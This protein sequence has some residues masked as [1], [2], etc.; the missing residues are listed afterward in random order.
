MK[1]KESR[2]EN[3]LVVLLLN[4]MKN[5]TIADKATQLNL[6]GFSN[7]EIADFLETSPQVIANALSVSRK[8]KKPKRKK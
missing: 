4:S 2:I 6:A 3:L 8:T 7:I 5:A 1:E